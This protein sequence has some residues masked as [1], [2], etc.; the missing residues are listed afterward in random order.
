LRA[1]E[2][3]LLAGLGIQSVP[4]FRRPRVAILSTGDELVSPDETPV[5]GQVRDINSLTLAALSRQAGA[6]VLNLG[7]VRDD[8]EAL[9]VKTTEGLD[10]ADM[11]LV[12]GGSSVGARDFTLAVFQSLPDSEILFHGVS[13]SPG[14]PTILA[15][16]GKKSVWGIPGH[17]ASAMVVFLVFIRPL[18]KLLG[19]RSSPDGGPFSWVSARLSRNL[20]SAQG[21]DDFVRVR[22]ERE[23]NGWVAVP[24]LGKS[25]LISTLVDADGLV[26]IDRN[27]E[28]LYAGDEVRVLNLKYE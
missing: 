1:Q 17:V 6:Q 7:L 24:V 26:R 23:N 27:T 18:L 21:R 8:F 2:L 14:K 20:A 3:G 10:T 19:G 9:K 5:A 15:R 11:L 13:V 4:V 22:L 12:S 25:G 16:A 28:G